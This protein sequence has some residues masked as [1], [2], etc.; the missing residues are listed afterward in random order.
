M[1]RV[2]AIPSQCATSGPSRL[3]CSPWSTGSWAVG[4]TRWRWR[5][6]RLAAL[7]GR[8][9]GVYWIPVFELLE[10]RGLKACLVNARHLKQVP[11]RTSSRC[12]C[13]KSDYLDCQWIQRLHLLGLLAASFRPDAEMCALRSYL[14]HRAQLLQHRAPHILHEQK[15]LQQMDVQLTQVLTD[16]TGA[17]G[18]AIL[19]SIVAGERDAVKLA[20]LRNPACKSSQDEI[21]KALT[22]SW[23][24]EHLFVLKQ[25]LEL[26]DFYT[27][28]VAAC[29][30]AIE[31]HFSALKP[32]WEGA[33]PAR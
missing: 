6:S 2:I 24:P 14:R 23:Q 30:A 11:G 1:C 12:P 10:A 4:S 25:S 18:L 29:D 3:T 32:R 15:A 28:Q 27:A 33:P 8:T 7:A 16:V 22:G 21:A 19:R 20:G 26:Y 9:A 5:R 31:Q 13:G 17:T